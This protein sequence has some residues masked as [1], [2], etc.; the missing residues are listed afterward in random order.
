MKNMFISL[1][2]LISISTYADSSI[3]N[4]KETC[5]EAI[6]QA[7]NVG[8]N[9]RFKEP[10]LSAKLCNDVSQIGQATCMKLT[11]PNYY[12]LDDLK[13][14]CKDVSES[15]AICIAD[16]SKKQS[17]RDAK[18]HCQNPYEEEQV[19]GEQGVLIH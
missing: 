9:W 1:I 10:K 2:A 5:L 18:F 17:F 7:K 13:E 6:L 16:G 14:W 12:Q 3:S 19:S 15:E 8:Y 4:P 11:A